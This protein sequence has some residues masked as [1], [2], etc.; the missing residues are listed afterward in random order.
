LN[1][2]VALTGA[3]GNVA[4]LIRPYLAKQ[5]AL[6]LTD[7]KGV[8]PV[9][10]GERFFR[11]ELRSVRRLR[12]ALHGCDAVIHLGAIPH[13]DRFERLLDVNLRGTQA[14]LEAARAEGVHRVVLASTGHVTGFYPRKQL[15][16]AGM[17]VRP[18]SLYAVSKAA[19]EA[20]GRYYADNYGMEICC[21][22][23]GRVSEAPESTVDRNIWCSPRDLATLFAAAIETAELHF[24]VVYGVSDNAR[25]W[26]CT[27]A[28]RRLG[29]IARDSADGFAVRQ[30]ALTQIGEFVQGAEFAARDFAGDLRRFA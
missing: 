19:C 22:R 6:Q 28:A 21:V 24:E 27:K 20:L 1:R 9:H 14:V 3:A 8:R 13:E 17:P 2:R 7:R 30:P 5:Y 29:F 12:R 11:A 4:A 18:D 15:V 23:I 16:E 10:D 25:A 26:W